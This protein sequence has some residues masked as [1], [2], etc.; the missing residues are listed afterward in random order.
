MTP[1]TVVRSAALRGFRATVAV[2]GGDADRLAAVAGL[3]ARAV[4]TDDQLIPARALVALLEHAATTLDCPDL[5]LRVAARQDIGTLGPLDDVSPRLPTL[6]VAAGARTE[7]F[8][9]GRE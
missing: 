9:A 8:S 5:G 6:V 4:D 3:S 7:T 2:L 1:V